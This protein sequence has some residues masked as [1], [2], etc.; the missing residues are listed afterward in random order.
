MTTVVL[1]LSKVTVAF[2]APVVP[3][4]QMMH[5]IVVSSSTL[6]PL[7]RSGLVHRNDNGFAG[8]QRTSHIDLGYVVETWA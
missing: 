4:L 8:G 5:F 7:S 2:P 3:F 6:F 1:S